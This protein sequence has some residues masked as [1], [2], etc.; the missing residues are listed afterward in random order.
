MWKPKGGDSETYGQMQRKHRRPHV[1]RF[2]AVLSY[3]SI[4]YL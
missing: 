4:H 1:S 3:L 2:S